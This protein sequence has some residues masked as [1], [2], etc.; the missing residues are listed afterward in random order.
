MLYVSALASPAPKSGDTTVVSPLFLLLCSG[1]TAT[2]AVRLAGSTRNMCRDKRPHNA[3][4]TL[5]VLPCYQGNHSVAIACLYGVTLVRQ[6]PY[7][8]TLSGHSD[9]RL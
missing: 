5:A 7:L 2:A 8:A 1:S 3:A 9:S 4:L 6:A